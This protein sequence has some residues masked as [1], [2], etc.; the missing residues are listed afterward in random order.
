MSSASL[1]PALSSTPAP[2]APRAPVWT[3]PGTARFLR[4][5]IALFLAGFSTFSLIYAVQPILPSLVDDFGVSPS[6]SAMALSL[7]TGF[8]AFAIF[9]AGA[10]GE[11]AGRRGLMFVSMT[12]AAVLHVASA[13]ITNWTL[14]L[15][16][17]AAEG[18]VL[19]GVPAVAMAYLAEEIHPRAL[20]ATMGL[21]VGGTAFGAMMGRVGMGLVT[22]MTSWRTALEIL[23]TIDF[24]SALG[25]LLLLPASRNFVRKPGMG[26]RE[27]RDA[28]LGHL[29]DW[30]MAVLFV[31]GFLALGQFVATFNYMTFRLI[32]APY[33]FG[34][35][36]ISAIF[37]S[38][39]FAVFASPIAG[40]LADRYG[41]G[42]ILT[43]S[44]LMIIA[45]QI[46]L[47][48]EPL[49]LVA[50]G[51]VTVTIGFFAVH[52][53]ASGWVGRLAKRHKGHASSL[54]LLAYYLGSSSMGVLGGWFW[55]AGKWPAVAGFN[56]ALAL[57]GL[58]IALAMTRSELRAARPA[59][60]DV[61]ISAFGAH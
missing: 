31:T 60:H 33:N 12:G 10:V 13:L 39:I 45:G 7:T 41:R 54:Y 52:A 20:G 5:R 36:S 2:P 22:A 57:T 50:L 24:L 42:K 58:V 16:L 15:I 19:G 51:V 23:G 53:V 14:F 35:A 1:S 3:E 26:W 27:H 21:Y 55:S 61:S 30:R 56:G 34:Q 25:F 37:V 59:S 28:W 43:A 46:M 9:C 44:T 49:A 17:R 48:F 29:R 11:S 47:L 8:L 4:I 18:F 40:Q 38:Y 32:E 6:Q